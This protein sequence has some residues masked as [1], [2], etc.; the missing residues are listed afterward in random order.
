LG[1]CRCVSAFGWRPDRPAALAHGRH[2]AA[3]HGAASGRAARAHETAPSRQMRPRSSN[4][5]SSTIFACVKFLGDPGTPYSR[6]IFRGTGQV[7]SQPG[8]DRGAIPYVISGVFH[9]LGH[10]RFISHRSR[11]GARDDGWAAPPA[12]M[13]A[14]NSWIV[15]V[16]CMPTARPAGRVA[17]HELQCGPPRPLRW[18]RVA[19]RT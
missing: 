11:C 3:R 14:W 18:Y 2:A 10:A 17:C 13:L 5:T 1:A 6:H 7:A 16:Q 4:A 12:T 15:P 8:G 19:G 9:C